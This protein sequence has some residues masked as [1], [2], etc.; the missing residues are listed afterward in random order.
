MLISKKGG[1]NMQEFYEKEEALLELS[2]GVFAK[3][4]IVAVKNAYGNVRYT[5]KP[6]DT[7]WQMTV[8]N[9]KKLK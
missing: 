7:N 5:V 3:A 8:E 6:V 9:L 2:K 4:K 1:G